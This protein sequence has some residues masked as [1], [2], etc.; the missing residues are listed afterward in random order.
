MKIKSIVAVGAMGVGLGI[1]GLVGGTTTASA[2]CSTGDPAPPAGPA[3]TPPLTPARV[4]CVTNEQLAEFA[5]TTS[6][7]YNIDVLLNGTVDGDG[8]NSGLGLLD[9]PSTFVNS[10]VGP[11]GFLDGPRSPDPAP[12]SANGF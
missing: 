8:N 5:R 4:A 3:Y 12:K 10:I 1:A 7:Q 6:P 11:G 2:D 9:Q